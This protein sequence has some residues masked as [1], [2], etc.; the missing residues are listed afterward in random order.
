M[1]SN[2]RRGK[3]SR[4][5]M[6]KSPAGKAHDDAP[7]QCKQIDANSRAT[8]RSQNQ[9]KRAMIVLRW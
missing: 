3:S 6:E 5:Q 7:G 2:G 4:R 1:A 8:A 9:R